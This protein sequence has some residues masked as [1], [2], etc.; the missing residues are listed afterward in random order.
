[1]SLYDE[2][3]HSQDRHKQYYKQQMLVEMYK[4]T[5]DKLL[6]AAPYFPIPTGA[7]D[8]VQGMT[9]TI[10]QR[11]KIPPVL[12]EGKGVDGSATIKYEEKYTYGRLRC[13]ST[14]WWGSC[15]KTG[16]TRYTEY[17]FGAYVYNRNANFDEEVTQY[18]TDD[19]I[20]RNKINSLCVN[21]C[22]NPNSLFDIG[23]LSTC[24]I[25]A[26]ITAFRARI[27]TYKDQSDRVM[28][29]IQNTSDFPQ[30]SQAKL[31]DNYIKNAYNWSP[32]MRWIRWYL[33]GQSRVTVLTKKQIE[34]KLTLWESQIKKLYGDCSLP[35][36][37]V[38]LNSNN[39]LNC[40]TV[41]YTKAEQT[42]GAAI[43]GS[44]GT[45]GGYGLEKLTDLW[46][47]VSNSIPGNMNSQSS[48]ILNTTTNSCQKWINMFNQWEKAEQAALSEPCIP[49]KPIE[50]TNDPVLIKKANEWSIAASSHI[51]QL[52]KRLNKIQLYIQNYPNILQLNK[53]DVTLAPYSLPVTAII[54]KD[55]NKS[56]NGESPMQYLEMIIPN[57]KPGP[58]GAQGPIG[59]QGRKY[60]GS[61]IAGPEGP[62]GKWMV[63]NK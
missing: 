34:G 45:G 32:S 23:G 20:M 8:D 29:K 7:T 49:E 14:D 10:T 24:G 33:P 18:I 11:T 36:T 21:N 4:D 15:D 58:P 50:S 22:D 52:M 38:G 27:K 61:G 62:P 37:H 13:I 48:L 12:I 31:T 51:E 39:V 63:P 44:K 17:V 30:Y 56:K 40:V 3:E 53:D 55:Y 2:Y 5:T 54:R 57:G 25:N 42:C 6:A 47:D 35:N 41:D 16:R 1:M 9:D 19:G 60:N 59:S 28:S 46:T 26:T 43:T